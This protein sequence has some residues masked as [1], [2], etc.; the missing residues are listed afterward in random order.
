MGRTIMILTVIAGMGG[1]GDWPSIE[2]IFVSS[3]IDQPLGALETGKTTRE[4]ELANDT[5]FEPTQLFVQR[6]SSQPPGESHTGRASSS[7]AGSVP[8]SNR[9][10]GRP[11]DPSERPSHHEI[12][13]VTQPRP[14]ETGVTPQIGEAPLKGGGKS[15]PASKRRGRVG[16]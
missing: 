8:G 9:D 7:P 2:G 3:P 14:E 15:H 1:L 6:K 5:V 4:I 10:S 12:G 16:K 11:L 13:G